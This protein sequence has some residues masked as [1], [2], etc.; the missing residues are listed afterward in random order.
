MHS[1]VAAVLPALTLLRARFRGMLGAYPEL[2]DG[3]SPAAVSPDELR[4]LAQGWIAAGARIVGGCCGATPE[5]VRALAS[6]AHGSGI[7]PTSFGT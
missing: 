3:S 1:P 2:G 4:A 6:L 7:G 5:H